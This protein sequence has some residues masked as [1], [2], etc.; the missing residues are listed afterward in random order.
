MSHQP[1][2]LLIETRDLT[3]WYPHSPSMVFY[4]NRFVLYKNDF[5]LLSGKTW[6]GKSTLA[7]LILRQYDFPHSMV[8]YKNQD[9]SRFSDDEVQMYRRKIGFVFQDYKLLE[10]KTVLENIVYPLSILGAPPMHKTNKLTK[11]IQT[12]G[13]EK[14]QD[15]ITKYLSG[16]EKQLVSIA[17]AL[18]HDPEFIIADEPTWNLDPESA[19]HVADVLIQ[20]HQMGN[21]ILFITHNTEL[22]QYIA[23]KTK[24]VEYTM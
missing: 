18:V 19:K 13:L 20:L 10:R 22:K 2:D 11:I 15:T 21:T 4:N 14:Q 16:G 24:T 23:S 8:Y 5:C 6:S 17:R 7:K 9:L 12:V 3:W 1:H